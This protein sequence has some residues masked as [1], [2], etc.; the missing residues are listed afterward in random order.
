MRSEEQIK[1]TIRALEKLKDLD[2]VNHADLE[3]DYGKHWAA[4]FDDLN[5]LKVVNSPDRNLV[6]KVNQNYIA[7]ALA[8]YEAILDDYKNTSRTN[9]RSWF[10]L[11]ISIL[12]IIV[13]VLL[14]LLSK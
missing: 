13:S 6:V 9:I 8:H 7:P 4:V 10:A 14:K 2:Q 5:A 1:D 3:R 12:S 11:V